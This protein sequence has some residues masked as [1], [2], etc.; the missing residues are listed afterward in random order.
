MEHHKVS[1]A[2]MAMYLKGI[3]F[4]ADKHKIIETARSNGAP[5]DVMMFFNR[6]PERQYSYPTEV[7]QEFGKLK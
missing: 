4:P 7:E 3:D 6:L 1:A 5:E 2:Q